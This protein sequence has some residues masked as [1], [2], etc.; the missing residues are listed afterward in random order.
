MDL[1]GAYSSL[2]LV[3][4]GHE[5]TNEIGRLLGQGAGSGDV[6]LL[7]G[8]LGAGKTCLTQGI[9]W[10]LGVEGYT[11]S[12][13]FV[14]VSKYRGRLTLH[15]IDLFRIDDPRE[16]LD[17]GLEEYISGGD[18]CVVEWADRATELFPQ[19]STWIVLEYGTR[20]TDR[21]IS[22]ETKCHGDRGLL[23]PLTRALED[24]EKGWSRV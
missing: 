7:S 10:G 15:H 9:A 17:L 16:A 11:R 12:P 20:E 6:F 14:L 13:T 23:R 22:I 4:H 8:T 3:S 24:P 5:A 21:I 18:V 2:N 19:A 1:E